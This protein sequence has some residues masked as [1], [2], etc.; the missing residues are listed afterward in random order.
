MHDDQYREVLSETANKLME[1]RS[2]V[3]DTIFHLAMAGELKE[4]SDAV[5]IGESFTFTKDIFEGCED[6]NIQLLTSL[7]TSIERT[8]DSICNLNSI[9]HPLDNEDDC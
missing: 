4:W 8:C 2:T 5:P 7:L 1:I 3:F 6:N 9:K